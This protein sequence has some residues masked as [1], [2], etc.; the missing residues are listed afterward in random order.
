V[1]IPGHGAVTNMTRAKADTYDYLL[2]LRQVVKEFRQNGGGIEAIGS[3]DQSR[4]SKLEGYD[5]LK[6]R[7]AQQVFQELEWE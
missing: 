7:N 5:L 1:V 3:V 4:F 6:G 2:S